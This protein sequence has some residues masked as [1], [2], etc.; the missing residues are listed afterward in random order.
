MPRGRKH[1][2]WLVLQ[3][4]PIA[5]LKRVKNLSKEYPVHDAKSSDGETPF[6]KL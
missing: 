4:M 1:P 5:P 3:N 2:S 6:L